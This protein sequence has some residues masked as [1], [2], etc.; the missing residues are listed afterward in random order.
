MNKN[1]F[2]NYIAENTECNQH[3]AKVIVDIFAQNIYLAM[4]EGYN[5]NI[6]NL[7]T[8]KTAII[9]SRKTTVPKIGKI[10]TVKQRRQPY[11]KPS[12]DLKIACNF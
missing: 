2:I 1:Q 4:S 5:I 10:V 8:F 6:D 7:G 12:Q 3:T 9:P 11:F